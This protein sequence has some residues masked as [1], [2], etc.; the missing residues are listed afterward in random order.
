MGNG[1]T[2]ERRAWQAELIR[3]WKPWEKSTGPRTEEGKENSQ[4]NALKHYM[5][6]AEEIDA[7]TG[8]KP[9]S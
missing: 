7:G 8:L 5:R 1:W 4:Y 2:P 3:Q 9:R 6:C